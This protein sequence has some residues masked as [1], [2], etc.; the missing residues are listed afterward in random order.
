[1]DDEYEL[2]IRRR[3]AKQLQK[4]VARQDQERVAEAIDALA[5]DPHPHGCVK[6]RGAPQGTFRIRVGLYRV[7]Y[8]VADDERIVLV[9]RIARRSEGTYR[10][11]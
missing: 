3:A 9:V 2:R 4:D 11:L 10:N 8:L 1:M 6:V 5:E 7:I